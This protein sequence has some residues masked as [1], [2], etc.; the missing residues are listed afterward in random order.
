MANAIPNL[1]PEY[2]GDVQAAI[3]AVTGLQT[4]VEQLDEH[5]RFGKVSFAAVPVGVKLQ[6]LKPLFDEWLRVPERMRGTTTLFELES[7]AAF[8]NRHKREESLIFI[9]DSDPL[10]PSISVVFDAHQPESVRLTT[11]AAEGE[12]GQEPEP[13]WQEFRAAYSFPMTPE[14]E[15]WHGVSG[16]WQTQ[17]SFAEFLEERIDEVLDPS[18]AGEA[19]TKMAEKLGFTLAGPTKLLDVSRGLHVRVNQNVVNAQNLT[20]GEI[21]VVFEEKHEAAGGGPS[22]VPG[23]FAII[24]PVFRGGALYRIPVRVRYRIESGRVLWQLLPH[25]L[26]RVFAD[27]IEGAAVDLRAKTAVP[28]LRGKP[29]RPGS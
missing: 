7:L 13:G 15:A 22:K 12:L 24:V 23:G 16:K 21:Q 17:G 29:S 20:T 25:R 28:V 27:A 5:A 19:A 2:R 4:K 18:E 26:D 11:A 9:D 8:V 14:W 3:E 1:P 6:S 10:K